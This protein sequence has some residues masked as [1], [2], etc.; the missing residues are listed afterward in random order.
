ML[1]CCCY[2]VPHVLFI[3]DKISVIDYEY[4]GMNYAAFDLGNFFCEFSG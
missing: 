2:L 3:A 4:A 1:L